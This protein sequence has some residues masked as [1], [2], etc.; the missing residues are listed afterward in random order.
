VPDPLE[1]PIKRLFSFKFFH[2]RGFGYAALMCAL[3]LF[4]VLSEALQ[5][6]R[7]IKPCGVRAI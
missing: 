7:P 3:L 5:M 2:D 4:V 1:F 6:R